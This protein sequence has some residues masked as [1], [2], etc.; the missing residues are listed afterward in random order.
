MGACSGDISNI[1]DALALRRLAMD[2]S[3]SDCNVFILDGNVE[4]LNASDEVHPS[5]VYIYIYIYIYKI[6]PAG[7]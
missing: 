3:I 7:M 4:D 1:A 5:T 6:V 2:A